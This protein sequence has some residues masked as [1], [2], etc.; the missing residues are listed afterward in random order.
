MKYSLDRKSIKNSA[1][2]W[3]ERRGVRV[4]DIAELVL[5]LQGN[6]IERLTIEDCIR[7]VERVLAKREV[8]N[9]ILTGIQLDMLAE[10]GLLENPLQEM[11]EQDEGLYGVDET[12]ALSVTNVYGSIG[13]RKSVV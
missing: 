5:F 7:S 1:R 10:A 13:D 2:Q 12:L 3:L 9:A 6:Y 8:Q 11:V 4:K